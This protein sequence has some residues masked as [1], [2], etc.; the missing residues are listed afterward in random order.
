[1]AAQQ[2]Q[3]A[4]WHKKAVSENGKAKTAKDSDTGL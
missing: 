3:F 4:K 2:T 1:M